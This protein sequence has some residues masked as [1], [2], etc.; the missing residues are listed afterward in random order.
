MGKL[1]PADEQRLVLT[2]E[3]DAKCLKMLKLTALRK[4]IDAEE[5]AKEDYYKIYP[6]G[7]DGCGGFFCEYE[8]NRLRAE[9][10]KVLNGKA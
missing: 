10:E 3:E 5:Q 6:S 1:S 4:D 7:T 9:L 2:A 8:L